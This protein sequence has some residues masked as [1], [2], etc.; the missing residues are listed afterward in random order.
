MIVRP[1]LQIFSK[2]IFVVFVCLCPLVASSATEDAIFEK[3]SSVVMRMIGHEVLISAGDR[4]S[5]ILPIEQ[6][7]C[8]LKIPFENE[9]AVDPATLVS[10]VN[11]VMTQTRLASNYIVEVE[12]CESKQVV[13]SFQ[14]SSTMDPTQVPCSGR[15]L[16]KDCYSLFITLMD[17]PPAFATNNTTRTDG[18]LAG[19]LSAPDQAFS[20]KLVFLMVALFILISLIPFYFRQQKTVETDPNLFLIGASLFDKKNRSLSF[21]NN[22]VELSHKEAELLALLHSAA[23][24]PIAREVILQKVWGDE[25]DYVGRTLDVFV[26]KLRKKLESDEGV[27]IEN[28]RGVGYRLVVG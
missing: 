13:H 9:F 18:N 27:R 15:L 24:E 10:I 21:G 14:M 3:R 28:V 17:E 16:P 5:R 11:R 7:D 25:G 4:D 12:Q 2:R 26:S 20:F 6:I 19:S 22:S 8:R 1:F 23:N